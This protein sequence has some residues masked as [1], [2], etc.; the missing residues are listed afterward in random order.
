MKTNA[1]KSLRDRIAAHVRDIPR[2]GIRDFF[3]IVSSRDDVI[4]LGVG[5]PDFVTPWHIREAAITA[6]EQGVTSYTSN[7]GLLSLRKELSSYV[8]GLIGVEYSADR[9]ILVTVGVSEA[10]DLALR[11]L[12]EP[13]DEVLYHEPCYVSY[14]PII[15]FAHGVPVKIETSVE[16]SFRLTRAQLEEKVT[17]KTKVLI[18]N[19]PT[20]P[21][22]A[23]LSRKETEE[24]AAFAIEH[25]LIVLSDEIYGELSY[26]VQ[27]SSI[28]AV[29]GMRER[30]VY[31]HGFS[32][33]WAMTGFRLGFSCAPPELTEAMMKIHQYTMLC[34][35]VLSQR[36]ALEALQ[37]PAEDIAGMRESYAA[38]RNYMHSAFQEMG[39]E[40]FLPG[41]AFY[42]FPTIGK[43]GL[44]SYD[45]AM[46]LL[47]EE[48]VA[49]VP[50]TAFG[51]CGEGSVR[52]CF[53]TAF[54]D[55]KEAM[56]RIARFVS[57][58][59]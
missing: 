17:E 8:K 42:M 55:L 43:F 30:T 35:P 28:L 27:H 11:A 46:K 6:L 33:A 54:D 1:P 24:I 58:L 26:D 56:P 9:E 15:T 48:N 52:C 50:G 59:S 12:I 34:A 49:V 7:F 53:A 16:N 14:N 2:S 22:G 21:T 36:A 20:N 31:L 47:E 44:S 37:N 23:V 29:P 51:A 5:E 19:F 57:R 25:D 40:C 18:L 32:K 38:R 41:G 10:M 45:F 4:S 3:D 13:G 39:V